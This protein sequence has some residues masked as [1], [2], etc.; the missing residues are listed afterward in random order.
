MLRLL[1]S[2]LRHCLYAI[3]AFSDVS[4][5]A[6]AS[7]QQAA[8]NA[9]VDKVRPPLRVFSEIARAAGVC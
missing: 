2:S 6:I 1:G 3:V 9:S 8:L 4:I 7:R 5:A